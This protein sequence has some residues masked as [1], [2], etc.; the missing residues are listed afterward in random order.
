MGFRVLA[1]DD[2][3]WRPSNQMGVLNTDLAKQL[4]AKHLG[5]RLWR[6]RPA[7]RRRDIAIEPRR[8]STAARGDGPAPG[9][10]RA[11][12]AGPLSAVVVE[13]GHDPPTLQRHRDD[14]LWL[15]VGAPPE[16][17]Q[18]ARDG[19]GGPGLD[20]PGWPEGA[21]AGARGLKPIREEELAGALDH[22]LGLSRRRRSGPSPGPARPACRRRSGS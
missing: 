22:E 1:A 15:V 5:A 19:R 11:P 6:L 3:H 4:E 18:H 21:P 12:D 17:R 13:P 8:S 2:A 16:A 10:R 7:R 9:R 20:V 14:Q